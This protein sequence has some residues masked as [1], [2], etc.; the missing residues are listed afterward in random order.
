MCLD[1]LD[2][3]V[4]VAGW[5]QLVSKAMVGA[6]AVLRL[7]A[8][9]K[10]EVS[11]DA[12]GYLARAS[13]W[14]WLDPW[15]PSDREPA[16]I[17]IT[18]LVSGPFGYSTFPLQVLSLASSIAALFAVHHL[19][20]RWVGP[21]GQAVGMSVVALHPLLWRDAALGI[22]EPTVL[23]LVVA[24]AIAALDRRP[25]APGVLAALLVMIR[26]EIGLL[27]L[28]LILVGTLSSRL[29]Y[30]ALAFAFCLP[31]TLMAPFLLSNAQH[32]GDAMH[33]SNRHARYYR[34]IEDALRAGENP[35]EL[36]RFRGTPISWSEYY[37][38]YV[39][40]R[41]ALE[42]LGSGT[43]ALASSVAAFD[44][45]V[46]TSPSRQVIGGGLITACC[47]AL[48]RRR[49]DLLSRGQSDLAL[50]SAVFGIAVI[51]GYAALYRW[52]EL[53]LVSVSVLALALLMAAAIDQL[54]VRDAATPAT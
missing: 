11:A 48:Y 25:T 18:K 12:H 19:L 42:R 40:P 34:N 35:Y 1:H 39:G 7:I 50:A 17:A 8:V 23:L 3:D 22:R 13:D 31:A 26:W 54:Q 53:R 21:A 14:T 20:K 33:H 44:R 51:I 6:G 41:E 52:A 45:D 47:L 10:L 27:C 46:R 32:H 2:H 36:P 30:S 24:L 29:K 43:V 16:W 4:P 9:L 37:L 38:E 5:L 49:D 28:G 15:A